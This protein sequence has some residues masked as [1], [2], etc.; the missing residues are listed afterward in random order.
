[1]FIAYTAFRVQPVQTLEKFVNFKF[2]IVTNVRICSVE[3][4]SYKTLQSAKM[5]N[6]VPNGHK[7]H[8][9]GLKYY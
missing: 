4:K 6:L 9:V 5:F 3:R 8:C 1:M 2:N 7:V